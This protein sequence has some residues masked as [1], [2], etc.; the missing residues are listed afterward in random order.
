MRLES[1]AHPGDAS[2]TIAADAEE[3]AAFRRHVEAMQDTLLEIAA[4]WDAGDRAVVGEFEAAAI[5]AV[6]RQPNLLRPMFLR[7]GR[8]MIGH[9]PRAPRPARRR[10]RIRRPAYARP[11][12]APTTP[13]QVDHLQIREFALQAAWVAQL[14]EAAGELEDLVVNTADLEGD[15]I[16]QATGE[17]DRQPYELAMEI[18]KERHE[19]A[20]RALED[21]ILAW[22]AED[23]E[24]WPVFRLVILDPWRTP[25]GGWRPGV[26]RWVLVLGTDTIAAYLRNHP[27]G[28]DQSPD[29]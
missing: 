22:L 10:H 17:R 27:Y 6:M 5:A 3:V 11:T 15:A 1:K 18:V 24:H 28:E 2:W 23:P 29:Q 21:R 14:E 4:V 25:D 19:E 8:F 7:A 9:A 16:S 13:D 12:G 20:D 26:P